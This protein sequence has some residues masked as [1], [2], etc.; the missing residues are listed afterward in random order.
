MNQDSRLCTSRKPRGCGSRNDSLEGDR[1]ASGVEETSGSLT[2]TDGGERGRIIQRKHV[3]KVTEMGNH[4]V[5]CGRGHCSAA[6]Y[7]PWSFSGWGQ[8]SLDLVRS[9]G[10]FGGQ[11]VLG[12]GEI[13]IDGHF[14]SLPCSHQ[15]LLVV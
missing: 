4:E 15:D 11:R 6:G 7:E 1:V 9:L 14:R 10:P 3:C 13:P 2:S 12:P 5:A 8:L